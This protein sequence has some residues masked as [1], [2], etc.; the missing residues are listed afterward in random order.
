[1]T[2]HH[3]SRILLHPD[4]IKTFESREGVVELI[5]SKRNPGKLR[6]VKSVKHTGRHRPPAEARALS[7]HLL[8]NGGHHPN[9]IKMYTAEMSSNGFALMLFEYCTEGDLFKQ[10]QSRRHFSHKEFVEPGTVIRKHH[11]ANTLQ[12]SFA[13]RRSDA[14]YN[15]KGMLNGL[16]HMIEARQQ[17]HKT[18]NQFS[19]PYLGHREQS[20]GRRLR[21]EGFLYDS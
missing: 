7:R 5:S 14:Q 18:P 11:I 20:L 13:T 1:M 17:D 3:C 9:I 12:C 6:T 19:Q 4:T 21:R 15:A 10:L 2:D 8:A 16:E